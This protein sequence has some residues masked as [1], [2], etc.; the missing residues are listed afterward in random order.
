MERDLFDWSGWDLLDDAL[1]QFYGCVLK[2]PIR[3][4]KVGDTVPS[5]IVNFESGT[6]S[7]YDAGRVGK[8]ELISDHKVR[9]VLVN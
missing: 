2:V 6:L 7:L 5:I 9:M 1:L 8:S 3:E 4:F